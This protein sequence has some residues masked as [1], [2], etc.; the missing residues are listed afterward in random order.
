MKTYALQSRKALKELGITPAWLIKNYPIELKRFRLACDMGETGIELKQSTNNSLTPAGHAWLKLAE[1][2]PIRV[3][4]AG[5]PVPTLEAALITRVKKSPLHLREIPIEHQ[6]EVVRLAAV[7]MSGR[8]IQ[9]IPIDQ[10]SEAVRLAAVKVTCYAL[11][12][13][14]PD[15]RSE[16]LMLEAVK[17][18]GYALQFIPIDKQ[19]EAVR[20]A[21]VKSHAEALQFIPHEQQSEAVR[22]CAYQQSDTALE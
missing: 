4:I 8:A 17:A 1:Q 2:W 13:I 9:F 3:E 18:D 20:I 19:S 11:E 21:A 7:S 6:S 5:I 16:A 15:Q 22:L 14:P 12:F 10:Q